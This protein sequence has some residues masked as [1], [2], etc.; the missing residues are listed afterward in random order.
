MS[1]PKPYYEAEGIVI[2]NADCRDILPYLEPVDLVLTDPPY[3]ISQHIH[4]HRPLSSA[5]KLKNRILNT[6]NTE[7]DIAPSD[8]VF[9][10]IF[11]VSKNQVIW[12]GNYFNLPPCRGFIV[13]DKMQPWA[14]FSQAEYAW[15]SFSSPAK[16]FRLDKSTEL[17]KIHPTQKPCALFEWILKLYSKP[18]DIVLDPFLGSGTTVAACINLERQYIGIEISPDYVLASQQRI[19]KATEQRRLFL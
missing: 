12:G 16:L 7:W 15:A 1:L 13:W 18:G 3:G 11:R 5:G 6:G 19:K 4:S 17:E 8:E 2:Y 10:E 14:N 9:K